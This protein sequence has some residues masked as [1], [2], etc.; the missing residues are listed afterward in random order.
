MAK[1]KNRGGELQSQFSCGNFWI[2]V[3]LL[4]IDTANTLFPFLTINF[5]SPV[6]TVTA[7]TSATTQRLATMATPTPATPSS[8]SGEASDLESSG[9]GATDD[10]G[11]AT[12]IGGGAVE[13]GSGDN[14]VD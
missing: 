1:L 12:D 4:V 9:S 10:E 6:H 2:P 14:S 13:L 5:F 3:H 7:P 11:G 8:G